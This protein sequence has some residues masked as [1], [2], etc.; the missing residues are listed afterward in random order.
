MFITLKKA[1]IISLSK[2]DSR[3]VP[4]WMW[5]QEA[6]IMNNYGCDGKKIM[7]DGGHKKSPLPACIYFWKSPNK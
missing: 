6:L 5:R 1:V 4:V 3:N 2:G 7:G